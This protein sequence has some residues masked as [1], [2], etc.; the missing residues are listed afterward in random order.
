MILLAIDTPIV[1]PVAPFLLKQPE[2]AVA[3]FWCVLSPFRMNTSKSVSKQRTLSCFRMNT[4][5]EQGEGEEFPNSNFPPR[6]ASWCSCSSPA[7]I[8]VASQSSGCQLPHLL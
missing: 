1:N 8:G 2:R 4:Y 5:E 7:T 6:F 3:Q